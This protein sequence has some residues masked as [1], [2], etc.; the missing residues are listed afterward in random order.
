METFDRQ[1]FRTV[2]KTFAVS[3]STAAQSTTE[4]CSEMLPL[5]PRYSHF[6]RSRRETAEAIE[7]SK[8]FFANSEYLK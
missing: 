8:V 6:P 7:Q 3:K 5:A 4:F 1:L 2:A